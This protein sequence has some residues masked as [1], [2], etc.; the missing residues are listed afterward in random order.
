[1][2]FSI[3]RISAALIAG[4]LLIGLVRAAE[5]AAKGDVPKPDKDGFYSLFDGKS[6]DGWKVGKNPDTFKVEDGHIVVNGKGPSHL[7]YDGPVHDHDF[8]N[9]HIKV[10]MM[11]FPHANSGVYFHTKYQEEGWPDQG[12][13]AQV[14]ATHSDWIKT[15]SLYH[16]KDLKDPHHKDNEWVVYEV[17]VKGNHVTVKVNGD[18]VNDWTQPE[19]F[20]P[21]NGHPGRFL[22]HGTFA[23][24]GHDP[25]SKTYFR[26]VLVKPLDD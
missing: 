16:I 12:F 7:F 23:L 21:P 17:I 26:S 24:Q 13:E 8:K 25:G 19:G 18:T 4:A 15:G 5:P 10:E 6:L 3:P 1:M 9:F 22:Q 20:K 11:T 14:N 2:R